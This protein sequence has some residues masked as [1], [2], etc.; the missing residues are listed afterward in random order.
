MGNQEEKHGRKGSIKV[1][2]WD[3]GTSTSFEAKNYNVQNS[4]GIYRLIRNVTGQLNYRVNHLPPGSTQVIYVDV[5]GQN[6]SRETWNKITERIS[7][8]AIKGAKYEVRRIVEVK[9]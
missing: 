9:D 4:K 8:K 2:Y 3:A 6:I 7:K 1:D 5:R